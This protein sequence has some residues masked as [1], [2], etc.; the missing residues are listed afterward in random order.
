MND[1]IRAIERIS[2]MRLD[3]EDLYGLIGRLL[4]VPGTAAVLNVTLDEIERGRDDV[5]R[6][7]RSSR[8]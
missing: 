8:G 4:R 2:E 3:V 1:A 6:Q 5:E 7:M